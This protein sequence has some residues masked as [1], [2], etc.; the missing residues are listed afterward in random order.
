MSIITTNTSFGYNP[1]K[2]LWKE[3]LEKLHE[4]GFRISYFAETDRN[5]LFADYKY[6]YIHTAH[7]EFYM[8]NADNFENGLSVCP[9]LMVDH[10]HKIQA[11]YPV[12]VKTYGELINML[13]TPVNN[14][15]WKKDE[16]H[17][18]PLFHEL[19]VIYDGKTKLHILRSELAA[20]RERDILTNLDHIEM[21]RHD[22]DYC[23]LRFYKNEKD[24]FDFE[25]NSLRITG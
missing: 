24:W 14:R 3:L 12:T 13:N 10:Y 20:N 11:D 25:V 8:Q 18:C 17:K 4:D 9:Y 23:V 7:N 21:K 5:G 1:S 6:A 2:E 15:H 22:D 19:F 16:V